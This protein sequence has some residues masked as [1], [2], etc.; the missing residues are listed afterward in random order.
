MIRQQCLDMSTENEEPTLWDTGAAGPVVQAEGEELGLGVLP[1]VLV[2][3][4]VLGHQEV[5]PPQQRVLPPELDKAAAQ[6]PAGVC[7]GRVI[8]LASPPLNKTVQC[9]SNSISL[10]AA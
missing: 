4:D 7:S 1:I 9:K 5:R 3:G 8:T 10:V 2:P 6:V